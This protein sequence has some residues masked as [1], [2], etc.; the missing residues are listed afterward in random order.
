MWRTVEEELGQSGAWGTFCC[1]V[2]ACLA[3]VLVI[4]CQYATE[5]QYAT[6][7]TS[8]WGRVQVK[9]LSGKA[10]LS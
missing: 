5:V 3:V 10:W 4:L 9:W 6:D 1:I 7:D 8:N 2:A